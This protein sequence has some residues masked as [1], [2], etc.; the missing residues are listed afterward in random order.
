MIERPITQLEE[1]IFVTIDN[2]NLEKLKKRSGF[3]S[4]DDYPDFYKELAGENEVG[5]FLIFRL[6]KPM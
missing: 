5:R 3:L 1:G 4:K 2:N 6:L